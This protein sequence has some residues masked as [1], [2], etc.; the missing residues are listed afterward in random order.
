MPEFCNMPKHACKPGTHAAQDAWMQRLPG[1]IEKYGLSWEQAGQQAKQART[2][3]SN[4]VGSG[5]VADAT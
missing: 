5:T 2:A 4:V 3:S 1:L